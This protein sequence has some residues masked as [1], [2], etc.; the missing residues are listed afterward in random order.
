MWF[1]GTRT[2]EAAPEEVKAEVP[3][4]LV[5]TEVCKVRMLKAYKVLRKESLHRKL[6][7]D[8][9]PPHPGSGLISIPDLD[10][11]LS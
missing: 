4:E 9:Q 10:V 11:V 2:R 8:F 5:E 3:Q 7:G 6:L 1:E